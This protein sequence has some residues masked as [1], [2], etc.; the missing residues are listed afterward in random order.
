MILPFYP[1]E[2][3]INHQFPFSIPHVFSPSC[4]SY[5]YLTP[6]CTET[7]LDHRVRGQVPP[8]WSP[9]VLS[10]TLKHHETFPENHWLRLG[11]K[12][13]SYFGPVQSP[14]Y[15]PPPCLV[16]YREPMKVHHST[17][18]HQGSRAFLGSPGAQGGPKE[19]LK[20]Q[21]PPLTNSH[22]K[23]QTIVAVF[24]FV[25]QR[26]PCEVCEEL[27]YLIW[28]DWDDRKLTL[29]FP[30]LGI[31]CPP[32]DMFV[33]SNTPDL[34]RLQLRNTKVMGRFKAR[35]PLKS[36]ELRHLEEL[37][38]SISTG[39]NLGTGSSFIDYTWLVV[40]NMFYFSIYWE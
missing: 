40:W 34:V 11:W 14:K 30:P 8:D 35:A 37:T 12:R 6:S 16:L 24:D 15:Q 23:K 7:W 17:P 25:P 36:L 32:G 38:R 33:F 22:G 10:Q 20:Q 5:S 18:R 3:S 29:N 39:A 1:Y 9:G 4:K 31:L 28:V 26:N 19:L 13:D 27:I 2:I 21:E